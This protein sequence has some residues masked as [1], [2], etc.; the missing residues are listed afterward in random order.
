MT[1]KEFLSHAENS[2][3]PGQMETGYSAIWTHAQNALERNS[4]IP[5]AAV[6]RK[7]LLG[8]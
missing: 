6:G 5:T 1:E 7:V 8:L 3:H 2:Q 4:Y